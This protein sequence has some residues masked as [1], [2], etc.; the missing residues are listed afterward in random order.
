MSRKFLLIVCEGRSDETTLYKP[1]KNFIN[2]KNINIM[3]KITGG[4]IALKE[5]ATIETCIAELEKII[6]FYKSNYNLFPTDF[7]GV[8]HIIDTDGAFSKNDIYV[9]CDAGYYIKDDLIYTDDI[10][11]SKKQMKIS[12]KFIINYHL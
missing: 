8:Y 1:T 11:K 2:K 7:F 5:D 6:K 12:E 10:E 9:T 4:D 3:T